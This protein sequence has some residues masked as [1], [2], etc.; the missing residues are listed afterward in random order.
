M[1]QYQVITKAIYKRHRKKPHKKTPEI[2]VEE[3]EK[4]TKLLRDFSSQNVL[5]RLC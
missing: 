4:S 5:Y 3:N 1:I 2:T